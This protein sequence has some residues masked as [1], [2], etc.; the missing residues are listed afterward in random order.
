MSKSVNLASCSSLLNGQLEMTNDCYD[1][2]QLLLEVVGNPRELRFID[3][4]GDI[5]IIRLG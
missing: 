3:H 1:I 2:L 5:H 4:P